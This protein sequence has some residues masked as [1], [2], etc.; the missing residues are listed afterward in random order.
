MIRFVT[1]LKLL[2]L[3]VLAAAI[4]AGF[5]SIPA[6]ASLPVHWNVAGEPDGFMPRDWALIMP[7]GVTLLVW[8]VF[9]VVDRFADAEQRERGAYVADV[10]LTALTALMAAITVMTVLIGTG[11]ASN[12][13]QV[14]AVGFGLL[15]LVLGNAMPK[16]RPNM[17][18]GI[19]MPS[20]LHSE[21]NWAATHRLGGWLTIVGGIVLLVAAFVAPMQ[22][23][24]WWVIGCVILPMLIASAYSLVLASRG[25]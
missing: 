10:A 9:L 22:V 6:G 24:V 3:A 14:I 11:L 8:A 20:T 18:A 2:L 23:L 15:L 21:A 19:R 12:M 17:F 5:V 1:P 7:A 16:S 25:T 13:V 4:V